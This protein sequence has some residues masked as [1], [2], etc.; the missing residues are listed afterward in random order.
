MTLLIR[1]T[2]VTAVLL[3]TCLAVGSHHVRHAASANGS[4][5]GDQ[6]AITRLVQTALVGAATIARTLAGWAAA[7]PA[8]ALIACGILLLLIGIPQAIALLPRKV[9]R[10]PQRT[11]S[12]EQRRAGFARSGGRCEAETLLFTRCRRPASQG[13]HWFPH[14]KGGRTS[15]RNFA[16]LCAWHNLSKSAHTPTWW[17]TTRLEWRR[18]RYFPEGVERRPVAR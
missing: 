8:A 15:M 13:D 6:A 11:F 17:E 5:H 3:I 12:A 4:S 18:R 9:E 1:R 14:S 10:D 16:G 7:H 2:L